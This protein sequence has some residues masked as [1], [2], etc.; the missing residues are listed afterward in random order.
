VLIT[1]KI[2]ITPSVATS[3]ELGLEL[4]SPGEHIVFSGQQITL[5]NMIDLSVAT[6]WQNGRAVFNNETLAEAVAEMNRYTRRPIILSPDIAQQRISGNYSTGDSE[7]FATSLVELLPLTAT[8]RPE[9]ILLRR[10]VAKETNS[11]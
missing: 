2:Q 4:R 3:S 10:K 11:Y 1:G 5:H 6:A 9:Q 8:F 7:A